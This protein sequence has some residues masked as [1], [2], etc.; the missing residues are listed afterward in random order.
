MVFVLVLSILGARMGSWCMWQGKFI[1][2]QGWE[3]QEA[4]L[5]VC[6]TCIVWGGCCAILRGV[7][8]ML[9]MRLLLSRNLVSCPGETG[10]CVQEQCTGSSRELLTVSGLRGL[11]TVSLPLRLSV[12]HIQRPSLFSRPSFGNLLSSY[13]SHLIIFMSLPPHFLLFKKIVYSFH[14][15]PPSSQ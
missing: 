6:G 7:S 3:A 10:S 9:K 13:K 15:L 2:K 4:W 1:E 5:G 8:R 14:F 12:F 11:C